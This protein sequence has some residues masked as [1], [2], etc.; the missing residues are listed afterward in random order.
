VVIQEYEGAE[1]VI[2][3]LSRRLLDA[4]TRYTEMEQLCLCQYFTCTK[5]RH[6]FLNAEVRVICKADI[7]KHMLSA[8]ILKGRLGKWMYALSEYDITCQ[9]A[10]AVKGQA[11]ADLIT[12]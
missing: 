7:V 8:P 2:F 9:P 1:R 6:Y 3:Y 12:E 11:L 10:K 5:L 4:K